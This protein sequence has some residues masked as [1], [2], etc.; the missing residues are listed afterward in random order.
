MTKAINIT[1]N[2]NQKKPRLT[3]S[4]SLIDA[5][6]VVIGV[7]LYFVME[8]LNAIE[9]EI[10]NVFKYGNTLAFIACSFCDISHWNVI[11]LIIH[12][13][14]CVFTGKFVDGILC[15]T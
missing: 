5:S 9:M 12:H 4:S 8:I 10:C 13:V 14:T 3:A 2:M 15:G 1:K 7:S 11:A 6:S